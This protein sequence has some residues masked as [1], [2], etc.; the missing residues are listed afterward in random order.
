MK[1]FS[2]LLLVPV[3]LFIAST[4][5][6]L[7]QAPSR[8]SVAVFPVVFDDSGTTTSRAK[9]KEAMVEIFKKGGFKVHD[10]ASASKAWRSKGY[11]VPTT[12][13]PPST[14]QLAS[15][16]QT[17]GVKYVSTAH[18]TFHTRSIWVNLGPKTI[19]NS[20]ISVTIIESSTGKVVYEG[21]GEGRSD[22]KSDGL[23][24]AAALLVTPLVTAVSGGP[25]T[26]HETR[27]AQIASARALEKFVVVS[28]N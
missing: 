11:R 16:G 28:D 6:A 7:G 27:A 15:F 9:A 12:A 3:A 13:R 26:P 1:K 2:P 14:S 24:I 10:D 22:E 20:T 19:S 17:A 23:K 4:S 18:V 8:G 21:D 5:S 25:K